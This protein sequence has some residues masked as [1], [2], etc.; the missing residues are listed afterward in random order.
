M[1]IAMNTLDGF[2]DMEWPQ[3]PNIVY[4]FYF[5]VE[6][7]SQVIPLYVGQ[8]SVHVGRFGYYVTAPFSSQTDFK[9]GE[10]IRFL[11]ARGCYV[12]VRY[13]CSQSPRDDERQ[14]CEY[15][16]R[17]H[18]LLNDLPGYDYKKSSEDYERARVHTFME[19]ILAEAKK[20]NRNPAFGD[21]EGVTNF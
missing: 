18:R 15:F 8:S 6:T 13:K 5:R 3:V 12:G 4:V 19:D 11:R 16:R 7:A 2:V 14:L 17:N 21:K 10:A 1:V 20:L 9:V